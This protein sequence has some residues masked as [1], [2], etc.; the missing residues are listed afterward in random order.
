MTNWSKRLQR[1]LPFMVRR[2]MADSGQAAKKAV[3]N[4][5][6]SHI[7]RPVAWTTRSVIATKPHTNRLEVKV[8]FKDD[9]L[10]GNKGGTP[11]AEYLHPLARVHNKTGR[12][13]R[14]PKGTEWHLRRSGVLGPTQYIVP[15]GKGKYG[16]K[17]DSYGN[18]KGSKYTQVISALKGFNVAGYDANRSGSAR[19]QAKKSRFDVFVAGING[20]PTGIQQRIGR[21]PRKWKTGGPGRPPTTRMARGFVTVFSIID[22]PPTY[23]QTFPVQD[24]AGGMFERTFRGNFYKALTKE[25]QHQRARGR[26][27]FV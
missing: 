19:S 14:K 20:K 22:R 23:H 16:L 17:F 15:T 3:K 2:A 13:A 26:N 5:I 25:V 7:N 27:P 18:I 10:T 11:A 21:K 1:Q 9:Y 6:P 4:A 12:E 24:I 8:G